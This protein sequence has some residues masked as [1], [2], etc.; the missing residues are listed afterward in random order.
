MIK[1]FASETKDMDDI[2]MATARISLLIAIVSTKILP[3]PNFTVNSRTKEKYDDKEVM[4]IA[5][6]MGKQLESH[7]KSIHIETDE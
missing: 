4:K 2:S 1:S 3:C 7:A 6:T 5:T